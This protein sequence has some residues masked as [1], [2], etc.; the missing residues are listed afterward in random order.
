MSNLEKIFTSIGYEEFS[1]RAVVYARRLKSKKQDPCP[2]KI[3]FNTVQDKIDAG[4][5]RDQ[6]FAKVVS[7]SDHVPISVEFQFPEKEGVR[8]KRLR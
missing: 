8:K 6:L 5:W 3:E 1:E 4:N 2:L 7:A